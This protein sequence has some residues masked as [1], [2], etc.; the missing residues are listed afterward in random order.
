MLIADSYLPIRTMP[1]DLWRKDLRII[2][3]FA[4]A[5]CCPTP[6]FSASVPLFNAA[7]ASG[8]GHQDTA[9]VCMVLE[10]L[11]GLP[12]HPPQRIPSS[13]TERS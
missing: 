4:N 10:A 8:Y 12:V 11:A 1:L 13:S 5:L 7:V 6:L 9:A 3:D 2:G